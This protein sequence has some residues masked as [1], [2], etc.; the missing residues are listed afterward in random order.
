MTNDLTLADAINAD[1]AR[2]GETVAQWA[3]REGVPV[4]TVESWL[5]RP[6]IGDMARLLAAR[7]K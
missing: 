6:P 1:R 7:L 5:S 3:K 2:R 4:R